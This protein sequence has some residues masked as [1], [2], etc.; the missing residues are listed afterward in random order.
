MGTALYTRLSAVQG[1]TYKTTLLGGRW[2]LGKA[3]IA[4]FGALWAVPAV[5]FVTGAVALAAGW[6]WWYQVIGVSTVL[7]L[8]FTILDWG[9]AFAGAILN[10]AVLA[11]LVLFALVRGLTS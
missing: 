10:L 5:G 9:Q 8:I 3:G 6:S 11:A 1:L 4:V 2:D 7:S